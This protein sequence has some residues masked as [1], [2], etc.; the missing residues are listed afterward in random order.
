MNDYITATSNN[1]ALTRIHPLSDNRSGIAPHI[2]VTDCICNELCYLKAFY[3]DKSDIAILMGQSV[4]R[5]K[6]H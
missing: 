5:L 3:S 4:G 6:C 2:E 1:V